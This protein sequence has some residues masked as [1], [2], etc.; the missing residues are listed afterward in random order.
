MK[1]IRAHQFG[2]P[3]VLSIEDVP[4]PQPG[5]EQVLVRVH[6]AGVNP[7]DTYIRAGTYARKPQLPYTPGSDGAGVVSAVGAA[8]TSV[9]RG[10][11][12]Y[13]TGTSGGTGTYA[14]LAIAD[15]RQV[16]LLPD[17]LS[18]GQGAAVGVP[19]GTAYRALFQRAHAVPGETVLVHGA[20]GGVG[21]AAIQIGRAC[22]LRMIGTAGTDRGLA[23]V[24]EQGA[25][26]VLN[27][28]A[29]DYLEELRQVTGGRGVDVI[30]EMLANVNLAKDLTVLAFNGR[31][32]VVGNRGTI[33]INPRDAMSRDA[34]ILGMT[35]FNVRDP[36]RA[37]IDAALNAGFRAGT[38]KPVVGREFPLADAPRAHEAVLE[39]GA[40][41]K[42][43]LLP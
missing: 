43:V 40:Y 38:L 25:D 9:R 8:A 12:V 18:F 42:I 7:V 20:S 23:L 31:V 5:P 19:Y 32:I 3:G 14:E 39:P 28:R 13:L 6:A 29:P 37:S 41:G 26:H 27:H 10:D 30:V 34:A 2:D 1:A 15:A 33:E 17:H 24:R 35:L 16:H 22:G 36:D 11:R 4:D 21:T